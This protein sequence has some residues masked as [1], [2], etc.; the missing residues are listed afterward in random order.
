MLSL[1]HPQAFVFV[2]NQ[3]QNCLLYFSTIMIKLNIYIFFSDFTFWERGPS[4]GDH[5]RQNV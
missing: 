5:C 3:Q 4:Q 2:K 1:L